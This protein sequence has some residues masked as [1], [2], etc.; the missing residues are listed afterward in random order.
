MYNT[1][2]KAVF[3]DRDNTLIYDKGYTYKTDDLSW[4]PGS[5]NCLQSFVSK[6]FKLV[7][8]TNQS[9]VARGYYNEKQLNKFHRYMNADLF[10]KTT[11]C[12]DKFYYCPHFLNGKV[13]KYRKRCNCRKPGNKLFKQAIAELLIE[14]KSSIV[15]GDNITD[16]VPAFDLGVCKGYLLNNNPD[17][18]PFCY[19]DPKKKIINVNNWDEII[20]NND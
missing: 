20:E 19:K 17:L 11:I 5:I 18:S 13:S 3:L 16:I 8:I 10:Q 4:I 1:V 15:I 14:P 7:V 12:I 2:N 6:G 9:G